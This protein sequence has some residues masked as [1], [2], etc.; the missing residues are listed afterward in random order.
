M[1]LDAVLAAGTITE[2]SLNTEIPSWDVAPGITNIGALGLTS[3]AK[4]KTKLSDT[5]KVYGAGLQ[6]APD[7]TLKGQ[8][9]GSDPLQVAFL[10]ACKNKT[11]MLIKATF[12]DKPTPSGTGTVGEF[13]FQPL[14]FELDDPTVEEWLMFT[15]PGKQNSLVTWTNPT[16]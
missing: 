8:Y 7:K 10:E 12:P 9:Y 6:D 4:E 5:Q 15:V 14:G 16:S 3:E 11:P 13:L 2:Y 1:S